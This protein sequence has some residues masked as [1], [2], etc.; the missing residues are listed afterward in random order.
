V[1]TKLHVSA[2]CAICG[3]VEVMCP[4]NWPDL[5]FDLKCEDEEA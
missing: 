5:P 3:A 2:K 4:E 1:K